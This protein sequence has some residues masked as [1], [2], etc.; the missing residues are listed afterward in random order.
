MVRLRLLMA[1][2]GLALLPAGGSAMPLQ[3]LELRELTGENPFAR[4]VY[5]CNCTTEQFDAVPLP[6]PNWEKNA[7]TGSGRLF[8]PDFGTNDP[9]TI[10]PGTP[11][12]LDLILEVPGDDHFFIARVLDGSFLGLTAQGAAASVQVARGTTYSFLSGRIV[13]TI[14]S[15]SGDD[16]V[17]FSMD[18]DLAQTFDPGL[19][20][21]LAGLLLPTGWTYASEVLTEQRTYVVQNGIAEVVAIANGGATFQKVFLPEPTLALLLLAGLV[22]LGARRRC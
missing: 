1:L 13:H 3:N 14:T 9:P 17:L 11:E 6:G 19:L 15:P 20:N 2:M 21:G 10:P 16:H 4:N 18:G 22:P 8:L 12:S 7:S 5:I